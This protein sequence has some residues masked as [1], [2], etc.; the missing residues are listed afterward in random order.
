MARSADSA[1]DRELTARL[2]ARG[3]TGSGARYERWRRAGL[4]PRHERHGAGRRR[5]SISVLDPVTV[6][7]AAPLARHAVQGRDLRAAVVAWFFEAG[8]P[9]LPGQLAVPEPPDAKVPESLAWAVR[10]DPSYRLLQRARSAVTEAQNDDFY[11]IAAGQARQIAR[12]AGGLD[13]SAMREALLSGKDIDFL[14][15]GKPAD[16]VHLTVAIG[17]GIEEVGAEAFADAIV[18]TGLFPQLTAQE[19]RDAMIEAFASGAYAKEFAA[20]ARFDPATAVENAGIQQLRQAREAATGLAGIGAML[21]MYGLL[22]PDTPALAALRAKISELGAGP[23]LISMAR[24]VM[25]PQ[26]VASAIASCLDPA[27][28][29]LYQSLLA[30]ITAGPPLLHQAGHDE[31]DPERF[32]ETWLSSIRAVSRRSEPDGKP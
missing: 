11:A 23:T 20:L 7:I 6:E 1:A 5:G 10:T 13:P 8:R 14:S 19:W 30:L 28:A 32:K 12:S 18:A 3:L 29:T 16:L 22:M 21:V 4:L 31:H 2:A 15:S 9:A 25:H 27:H 26:S 17:L 24:Q